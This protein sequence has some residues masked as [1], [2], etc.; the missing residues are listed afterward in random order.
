MHFEPFDKMLT[1]CNV[2]AIL[3]SSVC[4]GLTVQ[5]LRRRQPARNSIALS[6]ASTRS[7]RRLNGD[8]SRR[9]TTMKQ[10]R[11]S[12]SACELAGKRAGLSRASLK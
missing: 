10:P 4:P 11:G 8:E 2:I 6:V 3:A 12:I 9:V 5:S 1:D 7:G